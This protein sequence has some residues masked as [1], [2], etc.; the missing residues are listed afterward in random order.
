[1][2]KKILTILLCILTCF[3]FC[4]CG[5]GAE[6]DFT[7]KVEFKSFAEFKP[8]ARAFARKYD[9]QFV[10]LDFSDY[11]YD[12]IDYYFYGVSVDKETGDE[13]PFDAERDEF[14]FDFEKNTKDSPFSDHRYPYR[15]L[16][17]FTMISRKE[18]IR[19]NELSFEIVEDDE[20]FWLSKHCDVIYNGK[21]IFTVAM[22]IPSLDHIDKYDIMFEQMKESLV[23]IK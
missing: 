21:T 13:L 7:Q 5:G 1:M 14:R 11:D 22:A 18:K 17:T 4:S 20:G 2:K 15:V 3:C 10:A 12:V 19:M 9:V 16:G 8:Y 6:Y 23:L